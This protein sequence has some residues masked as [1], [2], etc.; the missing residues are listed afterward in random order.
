VSSPEIGSTVTAAGIVTNVHDTG[1]DPGGGTVLLLHGSGPG[2][3][4]WANW[5]MTIPSLA[6]HFR[7]IAPDL[8]GFGYTDRSAS[9]YDLPTWTSHALGV[10]D[11]LDI[12]SAHVV[13][14]SFGGSVAL[15]LAIHHRSRVRRL[16][17]MGAVGV[18]F[19]LTEGLEAVWGYEPSVQSMA[20]LIEL[21]TAKPVTGLAELAELRYL[22]S[23]QPGFQESFSAMFPAPRQRWVDAL[24]HDDEDI[25][26]I[27]CPT[28]IF[29]GREDRIIPLSCSLRL[30]DLIPDSQL[31]IFGECGHW[32][33]IEHADDFNQMLGSFLQGDITSAGTTPR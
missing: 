27:T 24:A 16:S 8:V 7:V 28:L 13:G 33:Q 31:H 4:A 18:S 3:S 30:L 26:S 12:E 9:S 22:A 2:V 17:L 15:S 14:N 11:A 10:L 23:I 29:H 1:V 20:Q 25:A 5:R 6:E 19:E 32:T 21:F